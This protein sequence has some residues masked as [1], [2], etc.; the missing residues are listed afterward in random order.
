MTPTKA[1]AATINPPNNMERANMA[2]SKKPQPKEDMPM[3]KGKG[4]GPIRK[5]GG[6]GNNC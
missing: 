4:K 5:R 6:Y 2:K 3:G 1:I